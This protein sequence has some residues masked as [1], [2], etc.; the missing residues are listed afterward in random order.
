MI[1]VAVS[2]PIRPDQR[3]RF[4]TDVVPLILGSPKPGGNLSIECFEGVGTPGSFLFVEQWN[5][6]EEMDAWLRS[7]RFQVVTGTYRDFLAG[8]PAAAQ[9]TG[10][11]MPA[12]A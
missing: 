2:L 1:T 4:V 3:D 8:P 10:S 12:P 7:E 5:S 6:L 11:L 9:L